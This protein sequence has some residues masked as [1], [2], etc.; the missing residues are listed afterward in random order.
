M[1]LESTWPLIQRNAS[2]RDRKT[3]IPVVTG[4]SVVCICIVVSDERTLELD[5]RR[6]CPYFGIYDLPLY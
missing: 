5:Q 6:G 1:K 3:E 2:G 4:L